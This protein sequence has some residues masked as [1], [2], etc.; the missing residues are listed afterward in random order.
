MGLVVGYGWYGWAV[1]PVIGYALGFE[2]ISPLMV[3]LTSLMSVYG[4]GVA[5][6]PFFYTG[7]WDLYLWLWG[8]YRWIII[9]IEP[10]RRRD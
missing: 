1:P 6:S 2:L 4:Y 8:W 5:S 7:L 9:L 3:A 10:A